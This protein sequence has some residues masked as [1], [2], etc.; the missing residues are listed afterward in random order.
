MPLCI[1]RSR[2]ALARAEFT[3]FMFL[4][5]E[6]HMVAEYVPRFYQALRLLGHVRGAEGPLVMSV[7]ARGTP[8]VSFFWGSVFGA[9]H[10]VDAQADDGVPTLGGRPLKEY[11]ESA[12]CEELLPHAGQRL[13]LTLAAKPKNTHRR[14]AIGEEYLSG[15]DGAR[16]KGNGVFR[17]LR[18]LNP[19]RVM[20]TSLHM[21][22]VRPLPPSCVRASIASVLR[23]CVHCL[24][25]AC[26]RACL[27]HPMVTVC[28]RAC[29]RGVSECASARCLARVG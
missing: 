20:P 10:S 18:P 13:G 5:N 7:R 26:V 2:A 9:A 12:G 8:S 16:V 15:G 6:E 14:L 27:R 22:E 3:S 23:A 17:V 1:A 21:A 4:R 28:V 19:E 24:R 25:L 29:L 11:Y